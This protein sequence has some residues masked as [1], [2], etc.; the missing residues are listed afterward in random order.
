MNSNSRWCLTTHLIVP[1]CGFLRFLR[2]PAKSG[3]PPLQPA[4][5]DG[6]SL[7]AR[8]E[9]HPLSSRQ[10]PRRE[11]AAAGANRSAGTAGGGAGSV[12]PP[13]P[14][15]RLT[16]GLL[17]L[18]GSS[19]MDLYAGIALSR[20]RVSVEPLRCPPRTG[21]GHRDARQARG[22]PLYPSSRFPARTSHL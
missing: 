20:E 1:H 18:F 11:R 14:V 2:R 15:P 13:R 10:L 16:P 6:C 4:A 7:V 9:Q 12:A 22:L 17:P 21:R 19:S 3:R 8:T 5:S